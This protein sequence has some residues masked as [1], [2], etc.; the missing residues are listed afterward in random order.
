MLE[1]MTSGTETAVPAKTN[2]AAVSRIK[3]FPDHSEGMKDVN[4]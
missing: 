2:K 4:K 1:T 3:T